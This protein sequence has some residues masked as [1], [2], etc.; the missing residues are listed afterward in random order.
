MKTCK[1]I[2]PKKKKACKIPVTFRLI[3]ESFSLN[4][5]MKGLQEA[6]QGSQEQVGMEMEGEERMVVAVVVERELSL[7][8][9]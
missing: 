6:L 2:K 5:K 3:K 8:K 4:Q 9:E 7:G 1:Y